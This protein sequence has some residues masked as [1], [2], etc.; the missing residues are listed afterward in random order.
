MTSIDGLITGLNTTQIISQLM[1]LER[2]PQTRLKQRQTEAQKIETE[3]REMRSDVQSIRN[4]AA[5]LRLGSGWDQL[6]ATSSH[7][8][9]SVSAGS[10][11]VSGEISFVVQQTAAAHTIYSN[12][13]VASLDSVITS[14]GGTSLSYTGTTALGFDNLVA[15]GFPAGPI[16]FEVTQDS[17]AA[18]ISGTTP[19]YPVTFTNGNGNV[20]IRVGGVDYALDIAAGTYTDA[21]SLA[22]A[23]D[24]ALTAAG[25]SGAV[26]VSVGASNELV[27]TTSNEGSAASLTVVGGNAASKLGLTGGTTATGTDGIVVVDGVTNTITDTS[28]GSATLSG[29]SGTVTAD[30]VGGIR[31]GT[32]NVENVGYGTGTLREVVDAINNADGLGYRA[33]AVNT[34]SGYRLQVMASETGATSLVDLD[35]SEF[36]AFSGFTTLVT[37]RDAQIQIQG[38]NPYTI[39]SA[40]NTFSDMLPGVD[41]TVTQPTTGPVTVTVGEDNE[42]QADAIAEIVE[43]VNSFLERADTATAANPGADPGILFGNS[44]V[45]RTRDAILRA[46]TDG[47]SSSTFEAASLAG[48]TVTDNG[49]L[50]FNRAEFIEASESDRSELE[51][52]FVAPTGDTDLG[53]LDRIVQAA[54]EATATGSGRLWSEAEATKSRIERW[55]DQID[56]F[57]KRFELREATLRRQYAALEV[58]LGALSEQSNYLAGQLAGL[59]TNYG[60]QGS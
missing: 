18:T 46:V 19:S 16:S 2:A 31:I 47:V 25:A 33:M 42:A 44:S 36:T 55:G 39:T 9:V 7:E 27:F 22:T 29:S 40:S 59:T 43:A 1:Q 17:A 28:A 38:D 32:A 51:R 48:I 52:L 4:M 58:A 8:S 20:D 49:R 35:T 23:V 11:N 30:I 45:R 60:G 3:L 21:A 57:E 13:T 12:E 10:G 24:Q 53:V 5:D 37:G 26:S 41:V 6:T 50:E 56:A 34:G 54:E 14:G 15:S